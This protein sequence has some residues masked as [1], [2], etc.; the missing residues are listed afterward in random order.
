MRRWH[1][2]YMDEGHIVVSLLSYTLEDALDA[3][4]GVNDR[5]F[6]RPLVFGM[7]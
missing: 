1:V 5:V 6:N 2:V 4:V 3:C 7:G